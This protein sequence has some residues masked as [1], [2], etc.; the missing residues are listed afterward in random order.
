MSFTSTVK[1]E[2]SS[3]ITNE[4][5]HVSELSAL[6]KTIGSFKDDVLL[7]TTENVSVANHLYRLLKEVYDIYARITVRNGYNF[8]KNYLYILEVNQRVSFIL[9]DLSI[10]EHHKVLPY[11]KEYIIAD[12][13]FIR[14]YLKGIF[15]GIGSVNDPSTSRYHLEFLVDNEEYAHFIAS[16]LNQYQFNSKVLKRENKYMI[17]MKE[18]EKI[19]D[20][21]RLVQANQAVLY[22]ENIR[23]YR[24]QKNMANRLNNCEQANVDKSIQT[25]ANLIHDITLL[26]EVGALEL[27][28][29]KV[30]EVAIYRRRYPEA[31]LGELSKIISLETGSAITKSGLHHRLNKIKELA[32][33]IRE[34]QRMEAQAE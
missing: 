22:Y 5:N 15:L 16:L 26:E 17:Y 24:E 34:K 8:N 14:A 1:N 3:S 32:Q 20:F 4:T 10:T 18:A 25:A 11:P 19:S 23:I 21:L 2:I 30:Y 12:D 28:D 31:S 33:K 9:N 7:L 13:D 6:V 27:L 29:E